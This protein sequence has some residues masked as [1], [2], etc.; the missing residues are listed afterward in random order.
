MANSMATLLAM[1]NQ[2][3]NGGYTVTNYLPTLRHPVGS[4]R[5][6]EIAVWYYQV[7]DACRFQRETASVA[8]SHLDR[9]MMTP[10]SAVARRHV[11]TYLLFA[12]TCFYTAVKTHDYLAMDPSFAANTLSGGIYSPQQV[13]ETE[14]SLL[15]ALRW[16]L[17][18]P[19]PLSFCRQLLALIP[20]NVLDSAARSIVYDAARF[21]I[22]M[23]LCESMLVEDGCTA[24]T[25]AIC[26]VTN[27]LECLAEDL[28]SDTT[29]HR[30]SHYLARVMNIQHNNNQM[31]TTIR[32]LLYARLMG[33]E[34]SADRFVSRRH[35][36]H[37]STVLLASPNKGN[38][39]HPHNEK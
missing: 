27:A 37:R 28:L 7:V 33:L 38:L 3:T 5:R 32:D 8:M 35:T 23:A 15:W 6:C 19:T 12:L 13:V 34:M 24:S 31:L 17:N 39:I 1:L 20:T 22:E 10:A 16:R 18:P 29:L 14:E 2:E 11:P 21:Q 9:Y 30:T 26:A 25:V 36:W 4:I